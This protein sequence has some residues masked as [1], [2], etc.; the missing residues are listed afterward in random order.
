[1]VL[2]AALAAVL[3]A[4]SL[5]ALGYAHSSIQ[6]VVRVT[7][8]SKQTR[9]GASGCPDGL[10]C[11]VPADQ[12]TALAA[13]RA[14]LPDFRPT[15]ESAQAKADSQDRYVVEVHGI[16]GAD[17][18]LLFRAQCLPGGG[19]VDSSMLSTADGARITV[20]GVPGASVSIVLLPT[21]P[22]ATLPTHQAEL[23]AASPLSQ[24]GRC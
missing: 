12:D 9:L 13:I 2:L 4:G 14:Y 15:F 11:A 19:K 22:S 24:I 16:V 21:H 10:V 8:T 17:V 7:D 1:M 20:G 5:G 6:R 18:T 3:L 23:I